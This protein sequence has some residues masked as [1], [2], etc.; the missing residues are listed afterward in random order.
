[1]LNRHFL[2]QYFMLLQYFRNQLRL[3]FFFYYR[4]HFLFLVFKLF[5]DF[6]VVLVVLHH[7]RLINTFIPWFGWFRCIS[8][9]TSTPNCS[10]LSLSTPDAIYPDGS[11]SL[12]HFY[13]VLVS[14]AYY[15]IPGF[16]LQ[17]LRVSAFLLREC[18]GNSAWL[19]REKRP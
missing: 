8:S 16:T 2:L 5:A 17:F 12:V 10:P 3:L 13:R 19:D 14:W 18:F 1:M 11:A 6:L 9:A 7:F 4:K 15:A